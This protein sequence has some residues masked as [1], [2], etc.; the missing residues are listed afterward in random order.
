MSLDLPG[1]ADPVADA[2]TTFRAVLEALAHPGRIL[3]AGAGLRPPPSLHPA[4]AAVLLTL[5][6]GDTTLWLSHECAPAAEWLAFHCGAV[7]AAVDRAAFAVAS[8]L[9]DLTQLPNGTDDAPELSATLIV[10]VTALGTG[11]HMTLTG[12]GLRAPGGLAVT[13]LPADF[14]A[15]WS[16]NHARYPRGVDL[17]LCAGAAL[18]AL[19]RS[20]SVTAA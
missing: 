6:D 10:Q 18:A 2:Q 17:L 14:P 15:I 1:F 3:A 9:P 11:Q 4:T 13:G 20:V 19:P 7:F 12:P 5:I 16:R 8:T